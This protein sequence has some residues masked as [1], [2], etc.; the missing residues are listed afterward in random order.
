M[1]YSRG[2]SE[3]SNYATDVTFH[4]LNSFENI[5]IEIKILKGYWELFL[6]FVGKKRKV[7]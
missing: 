2:I 7:L 6:K 4:L 3:Q 5:N 1:F